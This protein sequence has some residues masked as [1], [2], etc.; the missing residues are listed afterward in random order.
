MIRAVTFDY[1]NTLVYEE[2][3]HLRGMRA[4][5]W[6]GI[7]EGAG[8]AAEREA[9]GEIFDQTWSV[10]VE[11][12]VSN[13][14]LPSEAAAEIAVDK[15]CEK[16]GVEVPPDLR[17]ALVESFST[18]GEKAELHLTDGIEEC[19]RSLKD[20]GVKLGIVCDV[21]FTPSRIL[22]AFL[23]SRGVLSLFD[24]WAFS[25]EVGEYKPSPVIFKHVLDPLGVRPADAAHI[26]DLRRTDVAGALNLG[27]LAIRYTGVWEDEGDPEPEAHHVVR[28][29]KEFLALIE[30]LL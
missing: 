11:H 1:W 5:A 14:N 2:R 10:A 20:R 26:G 19:L 16:L 9:L 27:M 8:F 28:S 12:W 24:G 23:Q 17:G 18:I 22:R 4:A 21:G 15:L 13:S 6:A 3:G 25:D 30:H 29:H 7:L